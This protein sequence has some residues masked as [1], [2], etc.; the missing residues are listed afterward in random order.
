MKSLVATSIAL[1]TCTILWAQ[2]PEG[3]HSPSTVTTAAITG[4]NASWSST[5]NVSSSDDSYASFG[6]LT[7]G[8][9]SFT[10]YLVA[11]NFGFAIP[12]G[13]TI[14]GIV[15]EIER[16]DPNGRTADYRI[17][18][19]KNG[20][21]STAADR[22]GGASYS[23]TDTYQTFGNAVD[24]WGESWTS[25]DI[26]S[27]DFGI[28]IAA[29]RALTGSTTAGRIDHI[30]LTVYYLIPTLPLKLN[31]FTGRSVNR[32]VQL[33]WSTEAES[34]MDHFEV[35]HSVNGRVFNSILSIKAQNSSARHNYTATDLS[36]SAGMNQYRLKMV[37]TNGTVAY[38]KTIAVISNRN[39]SFS[40][41]P[42][43]VSRNTLLNLRNS[44]NQLV[45]ITTYT[46]NGVLL[47]T[48]Q[49]SGNSFMLSRVP[50]S[51]GVLHY[52]I[53]DTN[54]RILSSGALLVQ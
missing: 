29:Q 38:S 53:T 40:I 33:Q 44:G 50:I 2:I 31:S 42:T 14:T 3:P 32:D 20:V 46:E 37:E 30:R 15:A 12:G 17:R 7:A 23:A 34:D 11:T 39:Q 13:S 24:A 54:N 49:T 48:I 10:N 36:P 28:A 41:Y 9:G 52:R 19:V 27:T 22:S 1:F 35:E 18:I 8:L 45:R 6:N 25:S 16:S 5:G 47:E 51:K 4:S 26:N 21:I 43:V